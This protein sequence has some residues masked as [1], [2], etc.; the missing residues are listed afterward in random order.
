ML[1]NGWPFRNPV[2]FLNGI[3]R[4][5]TEEVSEWKLTPILIVK[6]KPKAYKNNFWGCV[7]RATLFP[8]TI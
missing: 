7:T 2:P 1:P 3:G 6:A 8:K 5:I 4:F